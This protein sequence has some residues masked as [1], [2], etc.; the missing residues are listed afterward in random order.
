MRRRSHHSG[1]C[2]GAIPCPGISP[3]PGL[4]RLT[5]RVS[6]IG[7]GRRGESEIRQGM[8]VIGAV[9]LLKSWFSAVLFESDAPQQQAVGRH[10]LVWKNIENR[11]CGGSP[12]RGLRFMSSARV[13][14]NMPDIS[15]GFKGS[16]HDHETSNCR[17]LGYDSD[18]LPCRRRRRP[19]RLFGH[20]AP[21]L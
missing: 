11:I 8:D 3:L 21:T 2:C 1:E 10:E 19:L 7:Y 15:R 6:W 16:L 18:G 4:I 12:M 17:L 9:C 14:I 20:G 5:A 13:L